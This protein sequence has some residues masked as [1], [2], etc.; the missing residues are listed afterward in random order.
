MKTA[1]GAGIAFIGFAIGLAL[2]FAT[3]VIIAR[4]GLQ[5]NYGIFSLGLATLNFA[6]VIA[7][8]GLMQGATRTIAFFHGKGDVPS[9]RSTLTATLQLA[10]LAS[11]ALGLAVFFAADLIA[12][13]LLNTPELSQP[14]RIFAIAIPFLT[15]I[16]VFASFFAASGG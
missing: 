3:R 7:S 5:A 9:I 10:S 14:L 2:S 12:T 1:R 11:L 13:G 4:Y 15:M 8:L 6:M 16:N